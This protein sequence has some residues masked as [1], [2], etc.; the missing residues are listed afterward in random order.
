MSLIMNIGISIPKKHLMYVLDSID[1]ANRRSRFLKYH[2]G[3]DFHVSYY[4]E[5]FVEILVFFD[6]NHSMNLSAG[7]A[8]PLFSANYR[9]HR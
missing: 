5:W 2:C 8:L 7:G 4:I 9:C 6:A 1:L 3:S